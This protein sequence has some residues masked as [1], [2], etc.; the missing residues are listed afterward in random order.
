MK[1]TNSLLLLGLLSTLSFSAMA[2]SRAYYE[3]DNDRLTRDQIRHD[4]RDAS[5]RTSMREYS[6]HADIC[7]DVKENLAIDTENYEANSAVSSEIAKEIASLSSSISAKESRLRSLSR[8]L[9]NATDEVVRIQ[10]LIDDKPALMNQ[11]ANNLETLRYEIPKNESLL[12]RLEDKKDQDCRGLGL[13]RRCR[14]AKSAVKEAKKKL[15]DLRDSR[16]AS[17]S[18]ISTLTNIDFTMSEAQK[19]K[20]KAQAKLTLEQQA[21]PT[22]ATMEGQLASAKTR[23]SMQRQ[24]LEDS[25]TRYA[26]TA[27]RAEKCEIM[28]FEARKSR[29]FNQAIIDLARDNGK[30]CAIAPERI[31]R[32]RGHAAR[33]AMREAFD[34]VCDSDTLVRYVPVNN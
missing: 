19:A 26:Q 14:N 8:S 28:K 9:T 10:G 2:Q 27:I 23:R 3:L 31:R 18:M 4:F 20:M 25:R 5:L 34:L 29:V 13:S 16:D 6:R 12:K 22:L 7:Q 17:E 15:E 30:N 1:K 11:H 32:M 33:E 21:I 24:N